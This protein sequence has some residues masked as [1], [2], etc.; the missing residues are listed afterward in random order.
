MQ[1]PAPNSFWQLIDGALVVNLDQRKDRWEQFQAATRDIIPT[2]KMHRLSACLGR[3]LPGYGQRP[4]FRGGKRDQTWAGRAGC[5][6]SHR[7]ALLQ[8][9]ERGWR[10]VL[11]LEDDAEF[12]PAFN[13][14][15]VALTTA[16]QE[17]DWQ[18][19]YL[20]FTEPWGPGRKLAELS[21]GFA[22][23]RVHGCT[24]THA[25]IVRDAARDWILE[26]LPDET[27]VW[28]WLATHRAID[29]WYQ[30]RLGLEFPVACVS[31]SLVNQSASASDIVMG[32]SAA[33]AGVTIAPAAPTMDNGLYHLGRAYRRIAVRL[34]CGV[35]ELRSLSRRW[36]GF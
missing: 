15:A 36:S 4:W 5:L 34:G 26:R 2:G 28:S 35:D 20:G 8:A 12:A 7:R 25:Y 14:I 30:R 24:T 6:L 33:S 13:S 18:I 1:T 32:G 11:L 16:L 22:L 21:S 29:R 23:H 17:Y 9:Q 3:E 19:C 10:T 27:N 31:P